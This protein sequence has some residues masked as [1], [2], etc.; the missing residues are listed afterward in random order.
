MNFKVGDRVWSY[1][2]NPPRLGVIRSIALELTYPFD[3]K[4]LD[5]G[6][7]Y[8]HTA[9]EMKLEGPEPVDECAAFFS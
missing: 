4:M 5:T 3:V 7:M 8:L 1:L 9:N 2:E 6:E